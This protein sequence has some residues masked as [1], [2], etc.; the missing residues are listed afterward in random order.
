MALEGNFRAAASPAGSASSGDEERDAEA[1]FSRTF[2]S[3]RAAALPRVMT[4]G[5]GKLLGQKQ[6]V[7]LP[8]ADNQ[9]FAG[10]DCPRDGDKS[11]D[12]P[13]TPRRTSVCRHP[14]GGS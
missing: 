12:C 8:F 3:V 5:F 9:R 7:K 13:E 10:A 6:A 14:A 2:G 4:A 11:T 1:I